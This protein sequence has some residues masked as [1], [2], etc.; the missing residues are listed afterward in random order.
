V[1]TPHTLIIGLDGATFDLIE[2]LVRAG[3]LPTIGRL[4][5][6]GAHGPLQA[7]PNMTSP[8]AW[9]SMVTGYNS[10]KH[11]IYHFGTTPPQR[12]AEWRPT[13]A[14][15]R[16]KDPFWMLLSAAGQQVGIINVPTTYPADPVN[17]FMLA[18]MDTPSVRSPGFAYP[19]D[20]RDELRRLGIDYVLDT[21]NLGA[22]SK[23]DPHRLPRPVR[24]MIEAR[25][26]TILHLMRTRPWD[27]LMA[28]FVAPDRLQHHFWPHDLSSVENADW[29]PVRRL[30]EQI[31]SFLSDALAV[32]GDKGTVLLVSDHGFGPMRSGKR[33]LNPLFERLGLLRY[34]HGEYRLRGRLLEKLLSLA[35]RTFPHRLTRSLTTAFPR[36]ALRAFSEEMYSGIDWSRTRV[37]SA[38]HGGSVLVNLQGRQPEGTVAPE[39]YDAMRGR[40]RHILLNL[41]DPTTGKRVVR[42]VK[43]REE[44]YHGPFLE[45]AS[46]L[47]IQW[48]Y[49]ALQ[50]DLCYDAEDERHIVSAPKGG[51]PDESWAGAH[52]SEGILI[53]HGPHI[54]RGATIAHATLYDIAPTILYLQD[55]PVPADMDGQVLTDIFTDD[56][57]RLCPIQQGEATS[58]SPREVEAVLD[59]E[60][61]RKIEERL[62][63]LGYID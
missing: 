30:Y 33:C 35:R 10:G 55:H 27:V 12:D 26:S 3:H 31:D 15:D 40:V 37:F 29:T 36:L 24:E 42:A 2:P 23:R 28:V 53:A 50:E 48:D 51:T 60:E 39:D 20:L 47:V 49:E 62:R 57:L 61:A 11:A 43:R 46:D 44:I 56:H 59:E 25:S 52:H 18:G 38:P 34:R 9:T 54:I 41:T 6:S 45:Q 21:P 63:G 4:I 16:K 17:G 22:L 19:S 8:A 1:N 32:M 7:W 5:A 13:T 14:A 58:P